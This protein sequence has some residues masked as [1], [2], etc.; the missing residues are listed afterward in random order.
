MLLDSFTYVIIVAGREINWADSVAVLDRRNHFR[1]RDVMV[2]QAMDKGPAKYRI[3]KSITDH[4]TDHVLQIELVRFEVLVDDD[5]LNFMNLLVRFGLVHYCI[6][7]HNS[8]LGKVENIVFLVGEAD[9][10]S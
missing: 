4:A 7:Y 3:F 2:D 5:S 6:P 10:A 8:D 9:S 1:H